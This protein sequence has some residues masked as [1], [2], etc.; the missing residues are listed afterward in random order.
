MSPRVLIF[1][2]TTLI[3]LT[4]AASAHAQSRCGETYRIEPG[5]TLYQVSQSCRVPLGRIMSLNPGL[6]ARDL[7][8]GEVLTLS[9][10]ASE[11]ETVETGPDRYEVQPGDTAFSIAQALGISVIE[12]LNENPDLDPLAMAVGEALNLP[13]ANEPSA[14][15]RVRPLSGPPGTEVQVNARGLRP[16]DYVT[17]GVGPNAA[18][19][20]AVDTA[21][22]AGDGELSVPATLPRW[23][24][25]GD[26]L[27]FVVDTD[28][29]ITLKSDVFDVT[30]R[31]T[32]GEGEISLEGR[33][34][35]GVECATLT[36]PDGDLWSLTGE[37]EFTPGEYARVEGT[38]AEISFCQQG[39]G[40]VSV[41]SYS[42]VA[43]PER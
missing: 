25:P 31:D 9:G 30:A 40:T 32:S 27:I 43:P 24:T 13:N 7:S 22:V 4:M 14:S 12:L 5:D 10:P 18:E 11:S 8:V 23:A 21:Q 42:E 39:V 3:S 35:E 19:W 38:R 1:T 34:S 37:I 33:V 28:R 17:I 6:D 2:T 20:R 15:V 26:T 16:M 29:G 41:D 36:T